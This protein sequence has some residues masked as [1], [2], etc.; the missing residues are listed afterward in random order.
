MRTTYQLNMLAGAM[1]DG[2]PVH[3][4]L[5]KPCNHFSR[6]VRQYDMTR[7]CGNCG[8]SWEHNKD[9]P[10][11]LGFVPNPDPLALIAA[12]Q[13]Q[14]WSITFSNVPGKCFL[15][16][17]CVAWNC[18]PDPCIL[19]YGSDNQSALIDAVFQATEADNWV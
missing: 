18:G 4:G 12:C 5:R 17:R 15:N 11:P 1:R 19:G 13:A 7:T 14:G 8:F 6:L 3:P 9:F 2:K 16:G 10:V